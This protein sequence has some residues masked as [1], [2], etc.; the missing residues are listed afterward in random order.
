[1]IIVVGIM[2][3]TVAFGDELEISKAWCQSMG[4]EAEFRLHDNARVDCLLSLYAVEVEYTNKWYESIGQSLYY[5]MMTERKPGILFIRKKG[6]SIHK[7]RI[8]RFMK[9]HKEF[10][11]WWI[12]GG[13]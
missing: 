13:E 10:K 7:A 12:D 5:A 8:D 2:I 11:V 1:M 9:V 6:D 3:A 4:G